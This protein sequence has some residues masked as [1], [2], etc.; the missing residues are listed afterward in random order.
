MLSEDVIE[1][2]YEFISRPNMHYLDIMMRYIQNFDLN[3]HQNC[4][5]IYVSTSGPTLSVISLLT[6]NAV[7]SGSIQDTKVKL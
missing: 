7:K 6:I 3:L 4:T 1:E 2:T 5:S